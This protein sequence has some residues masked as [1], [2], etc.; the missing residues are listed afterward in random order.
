MAENIEKQLEDICMML[1]ALAGGARSSAI[2]AIEEARQGN[3]DKSKELIAVAEDYL[4]QAGQ[5][6]FK[7]LQL[8]SG[9]ELSL[10]L[11]LIHAEDQYINIESVVL[12]SSKLA[13][14][15]E[16]FKK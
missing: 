11:L 14:M 13:Q 9:G 4:R 15:Y 2:Q 16:D 12:I 8:D 7:A 6:H 10:N 3:F 1:V 5:E